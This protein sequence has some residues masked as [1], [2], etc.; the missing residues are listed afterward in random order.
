MPLEMRQGIDRAVVAADEAR[1]ESAR[2]WL[3]RG[4]HALSHLPWLILIPILAF[5]FLKDAKRVRRTIVIAL[6]YRV[7]LRGHR[8]FEEMNATLAAAWPCILWP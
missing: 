3:Y 7:R 8:L 5:F 2:G 4:L 1:I 6:P